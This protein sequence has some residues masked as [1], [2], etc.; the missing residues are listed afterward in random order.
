MTGN[1]VTEAVFYHITFL[2]MFW[3]HLFGGGSTKN[4]K[5]RVSTG[6]TGYEW[7]KKYKNDKETEKAHKREKRKAYAKKAKS[8]ISKAF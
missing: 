7:A 2:Y 4:S 5:K 3:L 6:S 1:G 8:R